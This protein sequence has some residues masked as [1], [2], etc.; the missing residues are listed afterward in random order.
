[1][2]ARVLASGKQGWWPRVLGCSGLLRNKPRYHDSLH[3]GVRARF[4]FLF[5]S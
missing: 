5:S 3:E 4:S 1:M 2:K